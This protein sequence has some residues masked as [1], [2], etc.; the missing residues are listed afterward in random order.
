MRSEKPKPIEVRSGSVVVKS[1]RPRT[2]AR[3]TP[4]VSTTIGQADPEEF[5]D[6]ERQSPRP[7]VAAKLSN[8]EFQ[9]LTLRDQDKPIR[10][11][12]QALAPTGKSLEVACS[13]YADAV[14]TAERHGFNTE[15]VEFFAAHRPKDIVGSQ[16]GKL[17]KN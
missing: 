3:S 5:C 17:S 13:E 16:L 12:L 1:T 4:H 7:V 15:A 2:A 8:G 10:D 6:S 9:I 14:C 11:A